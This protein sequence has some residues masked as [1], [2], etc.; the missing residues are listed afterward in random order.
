MQPEYYSD[1][2]I[3]IDEIKRGLALDFLKRTQWPFQVDMSLKPLPALIGEYNWIIPPLSL[4][5][6]LRAHHLEEQGRVG[7][8]GLYAEEVLP[9]TTISN[10]HNCYYQG[11]LYCQ[12]ES[13]IKEIFA[14]LV[15]PDYLDEKDREKLY[16]LKMLLQDPPPKHLLFL[17]RRR[18]PVVIIAREEKPAALPPISGAVE[19]TLTFVTDLVEEHPYPLTEDTLQ[20]NFG[21]SG[22]KKK[23]VFCRPGECYGYD[24]FAENK[25]LEPLVTLAAGSC[26][27][28]AGDISEE[29]WQRLQVASLLGTGQNTLDGFGRFRINWDIHELL[30]PEE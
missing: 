24:V 5:I 9:G 10:P 16:D 3:D 19:F 18:L 8:D 27:F 17:G 26:G 22:L 1:N 12:E 20:R 15:A 13:A 4:L 30:T 7:K 25:P 21:I 29:H 14:P 6:D 23:R 11:N 28:F 2:L